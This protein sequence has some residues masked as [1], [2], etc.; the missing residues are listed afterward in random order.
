MAERSFEGLAGK[1]GVAPALVRYLGERH[2]AGDLSRDL[3]REQ[4]SGEM[5]RHI[6]DI[7]RK[8]G[9]LAIE[10]DPPQ[11]AGRLP[12]DEQWTVVDHVGAGGLSA[13]LGCR[14]IGL[15]WHTY[16]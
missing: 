3:E 15:L 16:H 2:R 13:G 6:A 7:E 5:V 9:R 14:T 11:R 12:H 8:V 1:A 4:Q 10:L